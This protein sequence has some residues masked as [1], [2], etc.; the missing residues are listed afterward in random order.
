MASQSHVNSTLDINITGNAATA[1]KL[2]TARTI[3]LT[4]K[5]GSS[6]I[7][8]DG[9][10]NISIATTVNLASADIP[11]NA[12]NTSGNAATATKLATARTISLGTDLTGSASFNG[13]ADITIAATISNNAVTDAKLRQSSGL[14]V[15]GR[16]AD[17]TGNV[18]DI[19]ATSNYQVL[20]RSGTSIGFGS[21]ALNQSAAVTGTL[22]VS[23]GGTG[24]SSIAAGG[25]L[26][27]SAAN[28]LS[29]IAPTA[30][31]Q[32]L[33]STG[34]NSL[35][36]GSLVAADIPNLSTA[37]LT[38]G[39]LGVPRGGTGQTTYTSGQLL[40]G[41]SSG[42]LSKATLTAGSNIDIANASGSITI[43]ATDTI[44][45]VRIGT[46]GTYKDG[47]L[48]FV[49]GANVS[50]SESSNRTYTFSSTN[51]ASAVSDILEASNSGT[52]I[53]YKP[54]T[55]NQSASS[56]PRLYTHA[57]NP[58]GTSRLN[59]SGYLYA[60]RLYDGGT[61]VSVSGHSHST[62]S[63]GNGLSGSDYNGTTARTWNLD[64]G[65]A[66]TTLSDST[67]SA[68][69]SVK[70]AREDHSHSHGTRGGGNLHSAATTSVAG[71]MSAADKAKLDGIA[72][73]ANKYT[74]PNEGGGSRS[75]LSGAVVISGITV[76]SK[77]HVTATTTRSMTAA[78][79]GAL[80]N[81]S[82]STQEG[83]FG[84]INVHDGSEGFVLEYNSNSK[85][86]EFNFIG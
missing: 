45:R 23:N 35:V 15:L 32:V 79:V 50:I 77:G 30:A 41:N 5:V 12:A 27:S 18:S 2:A 47:D 75:G 54:Y 67:N 61:R 85:C 10:K 58:T 71:F 42:T 33:R 21:I 6:A 20:R 22:R 39:T 3:Q 28:T 81:S 49:A 70:V 55:T 73:G 52:V 43:S 44:T 19:T 51:T 48:T 46:A 59:L 40:I 74:H 34:E 78:N 62:L 1:T 56:T 69:T 60:T 65:T 38:S 76:N 68:G 86:L 64:Y 83:S 11:N 63:A 26:Y 84:A 53:T 72:A 25:I 16:S 7:S 4:G 82:S 37:K 14:S 8:F 9:S 29:R 24:L 66:I 36:F 13:S 80:S 57:T 31:N 17:T